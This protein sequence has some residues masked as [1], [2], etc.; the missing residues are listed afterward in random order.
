[1]PLLN[2][3]PISVLVVEDQVVDFKLIS[4]ML[5]QS[6]LRQ[7]YEVTWASSFDEGLGRLRNHHYDVGLFDYNLGARTGLELLRSAISDGVEMPIILL[8][9]VDSAQLDDEALRLGAAD[10]V[11]KTGLT[12][13]EL[14]RSIRYAR[15]HYA[16][17]SELRRTSHLLNSVLSSLPVIAGRLDADG[18][19]T[20]AHGRGLESI[21]SDARQIVGLNAFDTWPE[22]APYIQSALDGGGSEF[23]CGVSRGGS[24]YYFDNYVLFDATLGRG[25]IG[26]SV[27]VTARVVAENERR[28]QAQLLESILQNLPVI[29]GRIGAGGV[30]LEVEGEGLAQ[31]GITPAHL[32]DRSIWDVFPSSRKAILS[33]LGGGYASFT[34]GG[35]SEDDEWTVDFF[36]SF[37]SV[38]REGAT[39]LGRDQ[40]ERRHLERQLLTVTD[41]EQQRIGA[42][43]HDGLGQELTGLAC[44]A[45]ALRDRLRAVL[46]QESAQAETI[47]R[48]ANEATV[49]SRALAHGLSPVQ[50]EEQ[51]LE[52]ALEDLA[53]QS[54]RLHGIQCEFVLRG[55][56]PR[57]DRFSAIHLY[58]IAQE[59]IHNAVRHGGAKRVKIA[60]LSR[61]ARCRLLVADNGQGFHPQSQSGGNG[62]GLRLMSYR[63]NM[64]GG[65]L[66]V[67]SVQ[68]HGSRI[69]CEWSQRGAAED[70]TSKGEAGLNSRISARRPVA[71]LAPSPAR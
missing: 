25:A 35:G 8:T 4:L 16:I 46:P 33:A 1:M 15:Q 19:V 36:V 43:L 26:F 62:R 10:Y 27:N 6:L 39:F 40:T 18:T 13:V 2:A 24:R 49:K 56:S 50:L 59:A 44:L 68:G 65:T 45:A 51:G 11:C 22:Y 9:G 20:E 53:E 69:C 60:L 52:A 28:R 31:Y 30:V 5:R 63:A 54:R 66:S 71:Q 47:A 34:V 21:E 7:R 57:L 37:D 38:R 17:Q 3:A 55:E 70:S 12:G 23:T 67:S 29:A 58:R 41:A 42:D 48:L 61:S 64:L 32:L 14:E